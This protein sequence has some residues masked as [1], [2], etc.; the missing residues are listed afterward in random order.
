MPVTSMVIGII[1]LLVVITNG[2]R[3]DRD[4]IRGFGFLVLV[5][6]ALGIEQLRARRRFGRKM[7]CAGIILGAIT[8]IVMAAKI[9]NQH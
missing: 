6:L 7:A 2:E 4:A 9:F 8:A 1:I 5:S 3:W